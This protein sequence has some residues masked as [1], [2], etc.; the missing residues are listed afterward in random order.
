MLGGPT[1]R[2]ELVP[3]SPLWRIGQNRRRSV[4]AACAVNRF[5][6][7]RAPRVLGNSSGI[8]PG[9]QRPINVDDSSR[10]AGGLG[11]LHIGLVSSGEASI[12]SVRWMQV[13]LLRQEIP[14]QRAVLIPVS[15][16]PKVERSGPSGLQRTRDVPADH[17]RTPVLLPRR[18]A[19]PLWREKATGA[20]P[21]ASMAAGCGESIQSSN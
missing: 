20:V 11:G 21:A 18:V 13:N 16:P 15:S 3:F 5:E 8:P 7:D 2:R 1:L 19:T 14:G 17:R 4:P 10:A 12:R 9:S 6:L